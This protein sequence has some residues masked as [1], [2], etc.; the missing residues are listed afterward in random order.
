MKKYYLI[1]SVR[2]KDGTEWGDEEPGV[3]ET[4]EEARERERQI[5]AND[6]DSR[7]GDW[8]GRVLWASVAIV[9]REEDDTMG[10]TVE[11]VEERETWRRDEARR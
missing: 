5:A 2:L 11:E 8:S 7:P 9:Q 6:R 10:E 1:H 3:Y 4:L